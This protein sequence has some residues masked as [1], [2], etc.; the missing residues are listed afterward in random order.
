MWI[1]NVDLSDWL[2]I[3]NIAISYTYDANCLFVPQL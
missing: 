3:R 2:L 1:L